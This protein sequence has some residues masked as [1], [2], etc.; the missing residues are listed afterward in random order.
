MRRVVLAVLLG[1]M[2]AG[3]ANAQ[4]GFTSLFNGKDLS[5][6]QGDPALWSVEEGAITGKTDGK[7]PYNKFLIWDGK[8]GDFEFRTKFRMEGS[9]NSG[10]QYR[11]AHLKDAGEFVVGGYQADIH[12]AANY[13]GMLYDERGRG[14]IAERGQKVTMKIDGTKDVA[15]LDAA[16]E[17]I[18]LTQWHELTIICQ[19]NHLVHKIDGV[20]TVDITDDDE[21]NRDLEGV[22]AFQVHAGPAM[23]V[24][25]KD[26]MIKSLADKKVSAKAKKARPELAK[27]SWIWLQENG[28]PAPK[29]LFRKE[30]EIKGAIAAARL[31]GTCDDQM[32]VYVDGQKVVEHGNW[33]EPVFVD[34]T[35]IL[36]KETPGGKHVIAVEAE[37]GKSAAGL[38]IKLVLESGWRDA[39]AEVTDDSWMVSIKAAKGWREAGFKVPGGW[40][41]ADVVGTIGGEP[42]KITDEQLLAA[43]G[44]KA[45]EATPIDKMMIAKGFH[46]D[47]LHSVPME[48]EG[49]WVSMCVD[50]KGRLIACDQYG[51]LFRI[52]PPGINGVTDLQIEKIDVNIGEAQG[53]LWAFDSLYVVV[54]TGG[55]FQSGLYRVRDT[56]NDDQLDSLETLRLLPGSGGEHGPHAIL[57][58]PDGQSLYVICGNKTDLTEFATSRVPRIWDEDNMLPRP[59]GRGFMKGVPAPGGYISKIDPDGK[60]WELVTVGYRNE[61][62]AA[63]NADGE[64]LTYDADMEW[65]MNLPWYRPTRICHS[66]SGVD[67]G[68]RNGGAKFPEYYADTVP[69]VVNIGPGSPTGVT[70]GYGAKFPAKYQKALFIN[71]WSYGKLYAVHLE[72]QGSSYT[73]KFEEFI[74]GT[75]LPLTDIVINPADGAMYFAIGGR[76]VQSGL[77]KVT[78]T[79]D[80]STAPTDAHDDAGAE[81][82]K[83]RRRLEELHLGDHPEAVEVAWPYLAHKDKYIRTAARTAIEHRPQE[84]W[85][86]KAVQ[87]EH[88]DAGLEGLLALCR[89]QERETKNPKEGV[90]T[91]PPLEFPIADGSA[92]PR[93]ML[94]VAILEAVGRLF[95]DHEGTYP[96]KLQALRIIQLA[97]LRLG[98]PVEELRD[99]ML[100]ALEPRLPSGR[101]EYDSMLLEILVF[102]QSPQ[103]ATK[104][105]ALLNNAPTQEEQIAY[106]K[107]LRHLQAGWN[108]ELRASYFDWFVRASGYKGGASFSMFVSEMKDDAVKL[109]SEEQKVALKPILEKKPEGQVTPLSVA[110]RP[111]VKEWTLEELL[112]Q[113]NGKL[114]NRDFDH[115]RKMFA[116]ANC[117][118]CHRFANE[119]GAVGPDLTGLAGRFDSKYI[120]E[121]ITDPSK[122]ISDQY[123]AVQISTL[124]GKVVVGRI[125]NLAGDSLKINTNMLDPDEIVSVDRKQIE[126]MQA[127]KVSMMPKGLLNTLNQDEALDLLA[128]LLSRGDRTN[129]MFKAE[130]AGN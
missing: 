15:K 55:K 122:V 6:W 44:L 56:N 16:V 72:P 17:A 1:L 47:L 102:L 30:V 7:L 76:R 9:N 37:N 4:E 116:A 59:Y 86:T 129:P 11:S 109:L 75:P 123:T 18:D 78:Y 95:K 107:A 58:A 130:G 89:V 90:D 77:Y 61:Y 64:L 84:E 67:Y 29:A 79:G 33:S 117:F 115:G 66:L 108:D 41:K 51:G 73:G 81:D 92:N 45:P 35:K 74:T 80:E 52:T 87:E 119:G 62:D 106:A 2:C 36:E 100:A 118:G 71:D 39:W 31:Y 34:V 24:Q 124:D 50:P 112:T 22:I 21:K 98:T 46:V 101:Y 82:R 12:P 83:L 54:N 14:I 5:G 127:S 19:G 63:F 42:W 125:M 104:G 120:L 68:W 27:P 8:A 85:L 105:V 3:I 57:L 28:E 53:L 49:S 10:V 103:A 26:I 20:V 91:V 96:Q 88:M 60:E 48:E 126:E 128:Y 113:V 94:Q 43:A 99:G 32:T 110:P 111:F 65:D 23:K 114:T 70:F 69:P 40:R 38:M 93:P 13:T 121:A 97:V 25:F